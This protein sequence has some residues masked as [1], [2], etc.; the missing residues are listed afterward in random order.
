MKA[1]I[2]KMMSIISVKTDRINKSVDGLQ[3][4]SINLFMV[5]IVLMQHRYHP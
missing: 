4:E 3:I 5:L 2:K 1:V